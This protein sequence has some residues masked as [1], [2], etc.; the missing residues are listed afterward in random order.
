M[1]NRA[2]FNLVFGFML[3]SLGCVGGSVRTEPVSGSVTVKGQPAKNVQ[4]YFV[5]EKLVAMGKTD[6][7]GKFQLVQGAVAGDN[8]VYFKESAANAGSKFAAQEGLDDY[9][10]QMAAGSGSSKPV[11]TK[12]QLPPDYTNAVEPKLNYVVPSGGTTTADFKL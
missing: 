8:K 11:T 4:I 12:S 1:L 10:A 9:Q 2:L 7:A 6:D 3:F 5:H